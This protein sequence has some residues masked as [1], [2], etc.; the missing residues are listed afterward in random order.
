MAFVGVVAFCI[1]E[2]KPFFVDVD[3]RFRRERDGENVDETV[4]RG[5]I[6]AGRNEN[7]I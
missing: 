4:A 7:S 6:P 2:C 1:F 5:H 3:S